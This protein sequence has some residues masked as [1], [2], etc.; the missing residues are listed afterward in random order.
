MEAVHLEVVAAEVAAVA[1]RNFRLADFFTH[2][3]ASIRPTTDRDVPELVE[4]INHAYSYQDEAKGEPRTN[5]A[6]LRKRI[7][8]TDFYTIVC[9]EQI[10]GCVYS[11]NHDGA[12]HFGLLTLSPRYRKQGIAE[13]VIAAV[14]SFAK[15]HEFSTVE[16]DYMSLAPWLKRYYEKYGYK[17]TGDI[18]PWGNINLIRMQKKML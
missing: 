1:G 8:E 12:L 10:A 13:S 9:N 3:Q 18:T 15:A 5:L 17:E 4:V 7:S 2:P 16:L 6:H 14:E 11:E